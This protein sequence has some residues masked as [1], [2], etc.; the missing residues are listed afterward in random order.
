[1]RKKAPD[2]S[3]T[4]T[5]NGYRMHMIGGVKKLGHAWAAEKALGH[6]LPKGAQVHHVN[7]DKTDNR[8]ENLVICPNNEYHKL[9]HKRQRALEVCGNANW[10][11][12]CYCRKY[13]D[14]KNMYVHSSGGWHKA[15]N[16]KYQ[17]NRR[18]ALKLDIDRSLK[19]RPHP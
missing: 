2:G 9:L 15:C 5:S 7:G 3:G 1:M 16:T 14:P 12:C 8:N 13:D 17:R 19:L 4:I 11:V 6:A 18:L 10:I